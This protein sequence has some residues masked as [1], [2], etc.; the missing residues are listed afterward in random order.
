MMMM[1]LFSLNWICVLSLFL[2]FGC[3]KS[4]DE[5]NKNIDNKSD[6]SDQPLEAILNHQPY[7]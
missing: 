4:S 2:F 3:G 7:L 1:K 6:S 5:S